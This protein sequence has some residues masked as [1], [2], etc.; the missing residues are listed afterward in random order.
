MATGIITS[1][2]AQTICV[3][4]LAGYLGVILRPIPG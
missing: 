1:R 2:L 3:G 4:E